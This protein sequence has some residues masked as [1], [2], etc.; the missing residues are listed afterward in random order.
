[1]YVVTVYG[2]VKLSSAV[3]PREVTPLNYQRMPFAR[4]PLKLLEATDTGLIG[5]SPEYCSI[6][7]IL[8]LGARCSLITA[9]VIFLL[10]KK[11]GA[12]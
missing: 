4:I 12:G 11:L 5:P 7:T 9:N 2:R 10:W 8:P 3:R 6:T 1:M